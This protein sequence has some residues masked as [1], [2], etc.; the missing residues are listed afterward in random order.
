MN[1]AEYR[2][3]VRQYAKRIGLD[4]DLAESVWQQES[5]GS[6]DTALK[7]PALSRGRGNAI[8][9]WQVVPAYHPNF[10]VNGDPIAQG[11]YAMDYLKEVGPARYYGTGQAPAGQPTT[12][13]YVQ[14]VMSRAG[15]PDVRMA[16]DTTGSTDTDR[17]PSGDP[18]TGRMLPPRPTMPTLPPF[19]SMAPGV[20]EEAPET[21]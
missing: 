20:P 4:P 8:G 17:T 10:P 16:A 6:L 5:S 14:Q 11:R 15:R 3:W 7:G 13:Q 18:V 1:A 19:P 12:Q 21:S 2:N 9:P